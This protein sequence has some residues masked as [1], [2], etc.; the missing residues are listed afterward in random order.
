LCCVTGR[1][2]T[3]LKLFEDA[4]FDSTK[5]PAYASVLIPSLMKANKFTAIDKICV[6]FMQNQVP[7]TNYLCT[8]MIRMYFDRDMSQRAYQV[9]EK[10]AQPSLEMFMLLF[11]DYSSLPFTYQMINKI[12]SGEMSSPL[13]DCILILAHARRARY[14]ECERIFNDIQNKDLSSWFSLLFAYRMGGRGDKAVELLDRMKQIVKPDARC[15]NTVISACSHG[16][17]VKQA[18]RIIEELKI[19]KMLNDSH[20]SS[21]VDAYARSGEL[22]KAQQI[23]LT[24]PQHSTV[25]TSVLGG[26]KKYSDYKRAE[27]V[28]KIMAENNMEDTS[29]HILLA[30]T[31]ASLGMLEER[32]RVRGWLD[33]KEMKK[34]PGRSVVKLGAEFVEYSVEDKHIT[35]EMEAFLDDMCN[36]L[37]HK[38]GYQPDLTCVL[39]ELPSDAKLKHLWRH[40]EKIALAAGLLRNNEDIEITINLRMCSD[41]HTAVKLISLH[42]KRRIAINDTFRGHVFEKGKCD[43][44]DFY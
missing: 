3:A 15:Y 17:F 14:D 22:D 33:E 40:S 28:I 4:K 7:L 9:F 23:A 19:N 32:D 1:F 27:Q 24:I 29:S 42:T 43:C 39:K 12:S 25:W 13:V 8:S 30:N 6:H 5:A 36:T 34:V 10:S 37:A 41:C 38:Y 11:S 31:Y 26:C 2:D 18:E 21:L 16:G 44:N 20:L 35:K